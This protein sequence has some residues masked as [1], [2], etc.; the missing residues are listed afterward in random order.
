MRIKNFQTKISFWSGVCLLSTAAF[1]VTN[2]AL[3]MHRWAAEHKAS[4]IIEAKQYAVSIAEKHA[5]GIKALLEIPLDSART[6]AQAF[7]GIKNPETLIEIDRQETNGILKILLTQN[8]HFYAVYTAWEE[9]AFDEMDRGYINDI[10]HDQ[11]GRYIPYWYRNEDN[12]LSVRPLKGYDT[13]DGEYYQIPKSTLQECILN[14]FFI[15]QKD[16]KVFIASLIAPIL[17][18]KIFYGIVGIDLILEKLQAQVNRIDDIYNGNARILILSHDNTIVAASSRPDVIGLSISTISNDMLFH[19]APSGQSPKRSSSRVEYLEVDT[20]ISPGTA[21]S[22]W[23]VRVIIPMSH[24]LM[25]AHQEMKA[26]RKDLYWMIVV[27]IFGVLIFMIIVWYSAGKLS[28][29]IRLSALAL[30]SIAEGK[31]DLTQRLPLHSKDEAGMMSQWFNRFMDNLQELVIGIVNGLN[32]L[33]DSVNNISVSIEKQVAILSQQSASVSEITGTMAELTTSSTQIAEHASKVAELSEKTLIN[34]KQ[35]V[36]IVQHLESTMEDINGENLRNVQEILALGKKS[37]EVNK[38]IEIINNITDQTKLIAFNAA[39]EASSAGNSG[40]RFSVVAVEIRRLADSVIDSTRETEIIINEI[41]A[42]INRM[43]IDSE[44]RAKSITK[45]LESASNTSDTFMN[46]VS[47]AQTTT[48]ASHQISLST[49]QQKSAS[50]QVISALREIDEGVKQSTESMKDIR[51]ICNEL[52]E[53]SSILRHLVDQFHVFEK[54][55]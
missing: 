5:F 1:I 42:S 44:K 35:G 28:Q 50:E 17:V 15:T 47:S 8:P 37:K 25:K 12:E 26:A 27:N 41:D 48:D 11:T 54:Q 52:Q 4:T 49:Q 20:P 53:L 16:Q 55:K 51:T 40:K 18:N 21:S 14:P 2:F 24:V 6:L 38:V 30:K 33:V 45:G 3:S 7:S 9:N 31:G 39:L 43:I 34:T 22:S 13:P 32:T 19:D 36:D 23:S 29:P 10:G 46:I